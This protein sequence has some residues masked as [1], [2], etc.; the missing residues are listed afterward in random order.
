MNNLTPLQEVTATLMAGMLSG[1]YA[2][3]TVIS[4]D[5]KAV[6]ETAINQAKALLEASKPEPLEWLQKENDNKSYSKGY[7]FEINWIGVHN[8][9]YSGIK[10][11]DFHGNFDTLDQAKAFAEHIRTR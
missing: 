8:S 1:L 7:E 4:V 11:E 3:T 2:D 10:F 5:F 9:L 6:R